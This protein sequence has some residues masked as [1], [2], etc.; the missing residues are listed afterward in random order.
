[1]TTAENNLA[2]IEREVESRSASLKKEL[3]LFDLVL[4]QVVK[5]LVARLRPVVPDPV[6]TAAGNSFPS[7]HALNV[8]VFFGALLL[9]FLPTIDRRV[10]F[11]SA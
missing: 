4:T 2:A 11:S 10:S 9:V 6:A 8:T 3:R 7:G 5:A 1:M